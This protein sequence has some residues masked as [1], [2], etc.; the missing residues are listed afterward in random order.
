MGDCWIQ[1]KNYR[2]AKN[3][4]TKLLQM[5]WILNNYQYEIVA[6]DKIGLYFFAKEDLGSAMYYHK[7]MANGMVEEK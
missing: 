7:K 1:L 6:Y 5:S 2:K 3:H 4:Y